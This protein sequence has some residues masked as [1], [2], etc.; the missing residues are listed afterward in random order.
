[1]YSTKNCPECGEI[2]H[3]R[4]DKRFC[5]DLCRNVYHNRERISESEAVK[6]V[7]LILSRNRKILNTCFQGRVR[8]VASSYLS[9]RG[10]DFR[11]FTHQSINPNGDVTLFCYEIGYQKLDNDKIALQRDMN[12]VRLLA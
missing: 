10:F 3:G 8:R 11:Y 5:S 4:S 2:V 7:N 9:A 1:M 12:R 6:E